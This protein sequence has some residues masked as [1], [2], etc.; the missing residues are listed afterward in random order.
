MSGYTGSGGALDNQYITNGASYITAAGV[1]TLDDISNA[2]L[3]TRLAALES[4]S[5]ASSA[6]EIVIGASSNDTIVITGNLQV[7]GTTTTINSTTITIDDKNIVL[8]SG[9]ANAAGLS[10]AGISIDATTNSITGYVANPE[11]KWNSTHPDFSQWQM[12]KGVTNESDV[13]IAGMTTATSTANLDNLTP[14]I[15]TFAMV[16]AALYIQTI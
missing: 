3:L 15:G 9:A 10:G 12:V 16:G 7:D 14:G 2:N 6:E 11:I 13:F 1:G 8:A 4:T 5:G